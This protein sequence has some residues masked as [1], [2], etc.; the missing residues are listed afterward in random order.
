ML[1]SCLGMDGPMVAIELIEAVKMQLE[2]NLALASF[3]L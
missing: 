3:G 2:E 1:R